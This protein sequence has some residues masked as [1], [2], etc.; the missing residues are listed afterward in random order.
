MTDKIVVKRYA[1]AFLSFAKETVGINQAIADCKNIRSILRDN[2]GFLGFLEAPGITYAEKAGFLEKVLNSDFSKEFLQFMKLLL[3]KGRIN[4]IQDI[5]EY[6]RFTYSHAE[7]LE[8]L[9]KTSFPLEIDLIQ[10]IKDKL[11]AKLKK[12][13][14]LYIDLDGSLLGGIQVVIGNT[15]IDGSVR[16]RLDDLKERLLTARMN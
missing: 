13:L 16:R 3:E 4:K 2:P 7:E 8:V 10:K 1:D 6:I 14:K 12:N 15:V 9:L 5:A 11:E